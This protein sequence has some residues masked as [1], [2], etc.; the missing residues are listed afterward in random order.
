VSTTLT[1]AFVGISSQDILST[2]LINVG[3]QY[4]NTEKTGAWKAALSFQGWY[5]IIDFSVSQS[6]RRVNEGDVQT[7]VG[8]I[9]VPN[10]TTY[11]S[12]TRNLTFSWVEKNVEAGLRLPLITTS[13][14]Y[15]GSFT[16]GNAIGLTRVSDFKNTINNSRY[17]PGLI[18]INNVKK[19][20]A[21]Y[22][23][24]FINYQGN[25]DLIYN[26]F[27]MTAYRLLKQSRR[28]IYSKWGQSFILDAYG[29]PYGGDYTGSQFSFYGI[30]YFPGLFKH[31][32]LWGYWG[33]QYS[34]MP[35]IASEPNNYVFRNG[36]PLPRGL[37]IIRYENL[38][39]MS[40]NYTLPVVYPDIALGPLLN[41][42]RIRMNGFMDYAFGSG[43]FGTTDTQT[44]TSAGVEV[45]FDINVMRLLPQLDVGFRY[46]IGIQPSTTL[47]EILIGTI[48]F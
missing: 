34:R 46:S 47:F 11:T 17:I 24:P 2:T 27:T 31:H 40:G 39:S 6:N 9:N 41:L 12:Q 42:Q 30:A 35:P 1:S 29:T 48:N 16:I 37:S 25:G 33:Y 32:S 4:D 36:I 38:Y 43:R 5:P 44:Y 21:T 26:H 15:Y 18:V 13:S 23:Y 7:T 20:T 10:D 28:D 22:V 19:D 14:K 3:Y 8:V 45:K